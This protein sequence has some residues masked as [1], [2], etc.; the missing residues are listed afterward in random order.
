LDLGDVDRQARRAAVDYDA[1][2]AAVALA[3][4]RDLEGMSERLD[5]R[6]DTPAYGAATLGRARSRARRLARRSAERQRRERRA[7]PSGVRPTA[8][9]AAAVALARRRGPQ[10]RWRERVLDRAE[11][12]PVR[13]AEPEALAQRARERARAARRR[14]LAAGQLP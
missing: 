2:T 1:D 3:E 4:R 13:D 10:S 12:A 11:A 6:E 7:T 8:A 5:R 14:E 9:H